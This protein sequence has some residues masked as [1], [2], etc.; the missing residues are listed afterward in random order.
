MLKKVWKKQR[1]LKDRPRLPEKLSLDI[2]I[3]QHT[4]LTSAISVKLVVME[5]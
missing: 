4:L 1:W 5:Q 2:K 3:T